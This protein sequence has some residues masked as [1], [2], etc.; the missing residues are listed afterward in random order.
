M[1]PN[2][3]IK[4]HLNEGERNMSIDDDYNGIIPDRID[5]YLLSKDENGHVN[6]ECRLTCTPLNF[7]D[8]VRMFPRLV[9]SAIDI[10]HYENNPRSI[11][12]NVVD[13]KLHVKIS[14]STA[15][16]YV[17]ECCFYNNQELTGKRRAQ[18]CF[19][20]LLITSLNPFLQGVLSQAGNYILSRFGKG[21]IKLNHNQFSTDAF[22]LHY[23]PLSATLSEKLTCWKLKHRDRKCEDY[24]NS[25]DLPHVIQTPI[26]EHDDLIPDTYRK[27]A[28]D[29]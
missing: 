29:R 15:H 6:R 18:M 24:M 8:I 16:E 7:R 19:N 10:A 17:C 13:N 4:F 1:R 11:I 27:N 23:V 21:L 22:E 5:S 20:C 25:P 28:Y 9:F 26:D 12:C 3:N 2:P 14:R